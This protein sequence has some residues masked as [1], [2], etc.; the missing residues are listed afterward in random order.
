MRDRSLI[1]AGIRTPMGAMNGSLAGIPAPELGASCIKDLV[2]RTGVPGDVIDEVIMGNVIGAGLGQNPARQAAIFGGL[3]KSVGAVTVNKV[4]GSGLKAVILADQAIRAGDAKIV[5]AGGMEN[6]TRAPYLLT[7][8]RE[9]YRLGHG[10]LYDAMILDGL[11]DVYGQKP[12]GTCGDLCASRYDFSRERQDDF[13]VRSHTRARRAIGDGVF[14]DEIVPIEITLKGKTTLVTADEGP[15]KFDETKLRA[16]KPAFGPEGT[17]TAGNASSISDGAAALLIASPDAGNFLRSRP[18][19]RIVGSATFSQEPEW[20]TTAPVGAV[21]K[22][23]DK[24]GWTVDQVDLFE[25]NEAF[26]VVTLFAERELKIPQEKV[27]IF[28]GAVALGHPIGCSGAR[29][30]VTLLNA[31]ARTGGKRGI[32]S[33]CI[34]GGEAV[35]V[36][37]EIVA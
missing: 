35:A 7:K 10:E 33:L 20:F 26:A 23:L 16:L 12:M 37:V 9:G 6:M 5:I 8:A 30:L 11:W 2:S 4:C 21:R 18:V 25:I 29:I 15:A 1:F 13:A 14:R 19:A 36:S 24:I 27:N 3:P 17:I 31:L 28:G 22:L 34:G 32:A